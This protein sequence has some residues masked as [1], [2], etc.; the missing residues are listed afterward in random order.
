M[1]NYDVNVLEVA[2]RRHG[3]ELRW[4]DLRDATFERLDLQAAWAL[5][6]N[7]QSH[8]TV[9]RLVGGRHWL[10]LRRFAGRWWNLDS[11]LPAP[12][13]VA[14]C[15]SS[16]ASGE[17]SHPGAPANGAAAGRAITAEDEG[18]SAAC[19]AAAGTAAAD[20]EEVDASQ[21]APVEPGATAAPASGADASLASAAAAADNDG[22]KAAVRRFLAHQV[23]QHDA[24]V[25]LVVDSPL[26]SHPL[27]DSPQDAAA[28]AAGS[29]G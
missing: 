17:Q 28:A 21:E 24:K 9:G 23:Q 7:V 3:K 13:L 10:A 16:P 19:H 20:S 27:Q 8:S 6:L 15:C 14:D 26:E 5:V 1:G 25:F 4:Y 2:L 29:T 11:N 18:G 12:R 22:D